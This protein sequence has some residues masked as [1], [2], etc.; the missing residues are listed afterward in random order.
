M[1]T[2]LA[3]ETRKPADARA[4]RDQATDDVIAAMASLVRTTK[5]IARGSQDRLGATGTPLGVLRAL[6]HAGGLDRP[7]DLAIATGV[8]PSVVSRVLAR[9]EQD[10]LVA[11]H[12][13]EEDARACHISLT[14]RGRRKL[15]AI[16]DDYRAVLGSGL[17]ELSD[18]DVD[19]IPALLGRLEQAVVRAAERRASRAP[20]AHSQQQPASPTTDESH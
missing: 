15:E 9:L 20:L 16:K 7:G 8:A 19:R 10:G 14:E 5:A 6:S 12:R 1:A 18:D 4:D 11:R 2:A 13:D 3:P 17:A